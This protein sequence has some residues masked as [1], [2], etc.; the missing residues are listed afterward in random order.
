[1]MPLPGR[2]LSSAVCR[3][4]EQSIL[5][6][7]G[8]G[9]QVNWRVSNVSFRSLDTI[10][11]SH[12]HADHVGGLPGVLF[13]IAFSGR[14]DPVAIYGPPG[15]VRVVDALL[16]IVGHLPFDLDVVEIEPGATR[17]LGTGLKL[18]TI[19]LSHRLPT[20]GYRL[21]LERAGKFDLNR[22]RELNVPQEIWS[23]LQAGGS[24]QGFTPEDVLG[25]PRPGLA[26]SFITDTR[27]VDGIDTFVADSDLLISECTY[28]DDADLERAVERGH[29]TLRQSTELARRAGVKALWLT[30]FSP[31]VER[32]MAHQNLARS[33]FP[34]SWIGYS[35]LQTTLR[36]QDL[37]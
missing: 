5:F 2:P 32:P 12:M 27:M 23:D 6:D 18:T 29:L 36:F 33:I 20:L 3:I 19:E 37:D 13:Q 16:T 34:A 31:K 24:V 1:M 26:V 22:A 4:G 35:G 15:T 11:L 8:E 14:S 10:L 30:H 21:D 9:T 17:T 25:P 28:V 7:C